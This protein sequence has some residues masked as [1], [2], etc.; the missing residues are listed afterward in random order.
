VTADQARGAGGSAHSQDFEGGRA[1]V[2]V[3]VLIAVGLGMLRYPATGLKP[4]IQEAA[5]E[6]QCP[7]PNEAGVAGDVRDFDMPASEIGDAVHCFIRE[8]ALDG[9]I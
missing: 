5:G 6:V 2:S 4:N 7:K 1:L 9:M 8:A 3:G